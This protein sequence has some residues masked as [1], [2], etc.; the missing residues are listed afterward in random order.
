MKKI[1]AFVIA[2]LTLFLN[3]LFTQEIFH[4]KQG[5]KYD[6]WEHLAQVPEHDF[7]FPFA[8]KPLEVVIDPDGWVLC[9]KQDFHKKSHRK[10]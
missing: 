9:Q 2:L 3:S 7:E 6:F 8:E 10:R 5:L 4:H 1:A